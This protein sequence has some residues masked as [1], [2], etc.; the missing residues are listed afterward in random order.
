MAVAAGDYHWRCVAT[1]IAAPGP[2]D[3]AISAS[4]LAVEG[5]GFPA[6][7]RVWARAIRRRRRLRPSNQTC[8]QH[9]FGPARIRRHL[10]ASMAL[11]NPMNWH[12]ALSEHG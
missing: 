4:Y 11:T 1:A 9:S 12:L 5:R 7:R 3:F 8:A 10:S 2:P 6:S